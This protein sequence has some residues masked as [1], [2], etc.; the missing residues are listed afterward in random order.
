MCYHHLTDT[1]FMPREDRIDQLIDTRHNK[2]I[3][4]HFC[5]VL[6]TWQIQFAV[7]TLPSLY[8][9]GAT[10]ARSWASWAHAFIESDDETRTCALRNPSAKVKFVLV[11]WK[12]WNQNRLVIF[13]DCDLEGVK[14]VSIPKK[15]VIYKSLSQVFRALNHYKVHAAGWRVKLHALANFAFCML[16][17]V[18]Y[19]CN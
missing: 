1:V 11:N 4:W 17:I 7:S 15:E 9:A 13:C 6:E 19:P 12:Y 3:C 14:M 18:D 10:T 2:S 16:C 5:F 8:A